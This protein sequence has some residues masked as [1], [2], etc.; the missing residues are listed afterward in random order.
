MVAFPKLL[1]YGTLIALKTKTKNPSGLL[2]GIFWEHCLGFV[3]VLI[4]FK[5]ICKL[6]VDVIELNNIQTAEHDS[7]T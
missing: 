1:S 2:G 6:S 5:L 7:R 4:E 3:S